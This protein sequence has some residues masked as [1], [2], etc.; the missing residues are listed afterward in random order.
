MLPNKQHEST[1]FTGSSSTLS[2]NFVYSRLHQHQAKI[3]EDGKHK[4]TLL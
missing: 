1:E 4:M 2:L 3:S